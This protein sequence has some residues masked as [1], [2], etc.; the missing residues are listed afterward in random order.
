MKHSV[1]AG[2]H[3]RIND[4]NLKSRSGGVYSNSTK[5]FLNEVQ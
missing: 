5:R 2:S 1:D 4:K 3:S